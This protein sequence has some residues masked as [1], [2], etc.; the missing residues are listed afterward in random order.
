MEQLLAD[1]DRAEAHWR[2]T[3]FWRP[4][5]ARLANAFRAEGGFTRFRSIN[6]GGMYLPRYGQNYDMAL[7]DKLW[8]IVEAENPE[9]TRPWLNQQLLG[10]IQAHRD[11]DVVAASWNQDTWPVDF[12]QCAMHFDTDFGQSYRLFGQESPARYDRAHL[13]YL[14]VLAVLS[15]HID[16]PPRSVLELGGGY[17]A[18]ATVLAGQPDFRYYVNVDIPPVLAVSTY[19]LS[20]AFGANRVLTGQQSGTLPAITPGVL[21]KRKK[22]VASIP[23]WHF[24]KVS[25]R[26]DLFVNTYSFQEMEPD[27]LRHYV[28]RIADI[29]PRYVVSLNS[30]QGKVRHTDV[31]ADDWE[32]GVI[33]PVTNALVE[34]TFADHG[35]QTLRIARAP[36]A[37]PQASILIMK[38]TRG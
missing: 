7:V 27:N 29:A 26:F 8:E 5:I 14:L 17:G 22:T 25:G 37:P 9:A 38:K 33:E 15:Q 1:M 3:Q 11:Y 34:A 31:T 18:L 28:E 6:E 20:S 10:A 36:W 13:N 19:Y 12:K 32:G 21:G 2:P 4:A 23:T 16:R 24:P 30:L 35:Y